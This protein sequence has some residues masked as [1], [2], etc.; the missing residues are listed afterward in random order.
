MKLSALAVLGALLGSLLWAPAAGAAP[1]APH[2]PVAHGAQRA[3]RAEPT[4]RTKG[5]RGTAPGSLT[6]YGF[7]TCDAPSQAVMDAWWE[8]SPYSAVGVYFGGVNRLCKTQA[9]LTAGWVRT[10]QHRGW[11][12]LP[13]YV[14]PQASCS[15]YPVTMAADRFV[16]EQQG[17]SEADQAVA[18]AQGL[19]IGKGATLYYDLEDYDIQQ[20]DC[21]Q[22]S[23]GFVSGWTKR[24]HELGYQSGVYS[25]VAAA[26]A[27][28][29]Y[30]SRADDA[31]YE[32]PDDIWFAWANGQADDVANDPS[33]APWVASSNWDDHDRV[34][35]YRTDVAETYG[36]YTL[37]IDQ[38]W[39]DVG[40]GSVAPVVKDL[41]KGVD[42]DLKRYPTLKAGR[43]GPAVEAAQCLLRRGHYTR[44]K[45]TG[46]YDAKTAAAVRKAQRKLG[47]RETGKLT[48][49]TWAALLVKGRTPVLKVGLTGEAVLRLQRGL[50]AAGKRTP[51]TGLYDTRTAKAVT[52]YQKKHGLVKTGVVTPDLWDSLAGR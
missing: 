38:N 29:D 47:L 46:K 4:E 13:L 51:V 43:K 42:V 52:T 12:L 49:T 14:G 34:H 2:G 33:R 30:A 3:E 22:A 37:P 26:I 5:P 25:N 27:A 40:L 41:C 15:G 19:G 39:V 11:H 32:E 8:Q 20:T 16:S 31:A 23:L 1:L 36:G 44:A 48:R 7:D 9:E 18:V 24:L 45:I 28:I 21:R 17:R 50:S 35:Q 10:Q 6:G